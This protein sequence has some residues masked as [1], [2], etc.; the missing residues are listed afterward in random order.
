M[1][2]VKIR[3]SKSEIRNNIKIQMFKIQNKNIPGLF[4]CFGYLYFG[5]L[6]LFRISIF[7]FRIYSPGSLIV[8]R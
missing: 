2:R 6:N 1:N 7:V 5:H 3:N 8:R 4:F